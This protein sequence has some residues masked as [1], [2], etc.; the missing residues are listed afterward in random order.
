MPRRPRLRFLGFD[1]VHAAFV[2]IV[3]AVVA[4][5]AATPVPG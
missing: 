2:F 3:F 1:V 4:D 5:E